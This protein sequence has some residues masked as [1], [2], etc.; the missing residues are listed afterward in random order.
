MMRTKARRVA[1]P[2]SE[3]NSGSR[4]ASE[5]NGESRC[6]SAEWMK[7]Y[8]AITPS[9]IK[10]IL[11]IRIQEPTRKFQNS[12]YRRVHISKRT[13][14]IPSPFCLPMVQEMLSARMMPE[15]C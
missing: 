7:R 2:I 13:H 4:K 14:E 5:R 10:K 11:I 15:T 8:A 3:A 9:S 6:T 12:I 1:L